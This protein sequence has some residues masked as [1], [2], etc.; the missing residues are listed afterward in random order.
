MYP[1]FLDPT[2]ILLIPAIILSIYAQG[3]VQATFQRYLKVP[4]SS[5]LTGSEVAR[6]LLAGSGVNDI[7]VE[8]INKTLGDHYDPRARVLRLSP[9]VYQSNSLAALGVAAHETGHAIQHHVGYFPL[10]FRSAFVPVAQFGSTLAFP[11]LLIGIIFGLPSLARF[12][13]YAFAAVVVFQLITLPVE[14]NASGRAIHLLETGGYISREEVGP[15]RS[16]LNA[17]ALT[18]LAAALVGILNLVRLL[19]LS[20]MFGG[21]DE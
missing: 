13:V 14:Y 9:E 20:G 17:A 8:M 4:A 7:S 5:R 11:L 19:I 12:G 21:R 16:V 1:F 18:Y 10:E 2:F 15:T 6:R 3:K